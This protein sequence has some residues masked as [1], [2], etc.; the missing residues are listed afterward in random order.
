MKIFGCPSG[1]PPVQMSAPSQ[2]AGVCD[3]SC[4]CARD[5]G[6]SNFTKTAIET[7]QHNISLSQT[8]CSLPSHL[9]TLTPQ[10]SH[11][12]ELS[13][14]RTLQQRPKPMGLR[15]SF[16]F[17][18][19]PQPHSFELFR[20]PNLTLTSRSKFTALPTHHHRKPPFDQSPSSRDPEPP[21]P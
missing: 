3:L 7:P 18:S 1:P 21:S 9:R 15:Q 19:S 17:C 14:L 12:S 11:T 8:D 20:R 4:Q 10:N 16:E 5:N 2:T 6:L 13:H